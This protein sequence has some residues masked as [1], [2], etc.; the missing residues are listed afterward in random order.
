MTG[1]HFTILNLLAVYTVHLMTDIYT[2]RS[3]PIYPYIIQKDDIAD[4]I[5]TAKQQRYTHLLGRKVAQPCELMVVGEAWLCLLMNTNIVIVADNPENNQKI[6][7]RHTYYTSNMTM[8]NVMNYT[9]TIYVLC[10]VMG[11]NVVIVGESPENNQ[12]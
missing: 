7:L 6:F 10:M 11:V 4:R 12:R 1:T 5:T 8:I 3:I 9:T 2:Y